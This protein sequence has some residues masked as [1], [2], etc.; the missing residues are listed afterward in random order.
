MDRRDLLKMIAAATGVA[1]VGGDLW[2]ADLKSAD[3]GKALF[4]QSDIAFLDEIAETILPKTSTPGAKDAGCAAVM[5]VM[6]TDCYELKFQTVFFEGLKTIKALAKKQFSQDFMQLTA[7][8]KRSKTAPTKLMPVQKPPAQF[9]QQRPAMQQ[10][11]HR[12][13]VF[14]HIGFDSSL[15]PIGQRVDLQAA[16][17]DLDDPTRVV[18]RLREPLLSPDENERAGYVPN[19]VYSCGGLIYRGT[20]ILPYGFSDCATRI[21]RVDVEALLGRMTPTRTRAELK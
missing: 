18:G 12:Q 3:A 15:V 13:C 8:Q 7:A 21:A 14:G 10:W 16:L 1:M 11:M 5:A 4:T 6:V 2:A 19:V 17:L 9:L 20:L